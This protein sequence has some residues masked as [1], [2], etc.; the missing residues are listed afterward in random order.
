MFAYMYAAGGQ[1]FKYVQN[2]FSYHYQIKY[3]SNFI[4]ATWIRGPV[5]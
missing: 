4:L 1:N 5:M 3:E 2:S